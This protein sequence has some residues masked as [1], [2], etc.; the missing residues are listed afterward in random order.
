[1]DSG[2]QRQ[3]P[4]ESARQFHVCKRC[5]QEG[6]PIGPHPFQ[7]RDLAFQG[8]GHLFEGRAAQ[9]SPRNEQSA[10]VQSAH[11]QARV[12]SIERRTRR[13][14]QAD[15]F[16]EDRPARTQ[17]H[18]PLRQRQD[19]ILYLEIFPRHAQAGPAGKVA[20]NPRQFQVT[21]RRLE[22]DRKGELGRD[23]SAGRK[24]RRGGG[25]SLT[26]KGQIPGSGEGAHPAF[27][28]GQAQ[29]Q[30]IDRK[31]SLGH[32]HAEPGVRQRQV[33]DVE[34]AG[35]RSQVR[36]AFRLPGARALEHDPPRFQ[37][38]QPRPAVEEAAGN[39]F[40]LQVVQAH[41]VAIARRT[42]DHESGKHDGRWGERYFQACQGSRSAPRSQRPL[43]PGPD[44]GRPVDRQGYGQCGD[45]QKDRQ[46]RGTPEGRS[47]QGHR[48]PP[49]TR[50]RSPSSG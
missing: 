26:A 49:A 37:V 10:D 16:R 47:S 15:R 28:R 12:P 31:Y 39:Q 23:G 3:A 40:E 6:S 18:P 44:Q 42:R 32:G 14:V 11:L 30:P 34:Q 43:R 24:L 7:S 2:G 21:R 17:V 41:E 50:D 1:M 45:S 27:P 19:Q 48:S 8:P 35:E 4:G 33:F 22:I 29:P 5:G 46:S 13:C 36:W 9:S 20:G 25:A 38:P